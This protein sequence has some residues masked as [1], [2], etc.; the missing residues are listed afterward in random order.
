MRRRWDLERNE[1]QQKNVFK[2]AIIRSFPRKLK[3]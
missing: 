1:Q 2:S 3:E